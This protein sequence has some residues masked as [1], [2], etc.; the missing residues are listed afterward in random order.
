MAPTLFAIAAALHS[1]AAASAPL[2]ASATID[3]QA[4]GVRIAPEV[5]G[6]FSEQLGRGI[7]DG[8]WVGEDSSIPNINGYRKDV[9]EALKDLHVPVLRW[10]GGCYADTYRWRDGIGPRA[11]RPVTLNK[12]WGNNEEHNAFGTHEYFNFAELIG[13]KTYLGINMGTATAG[14]A[15]DWVE[16]VTSPTGSALA[17]LRRA[18]GRERPW[19]VDYAGIGNESWG[20]GGNLTAAQYAPLMRMFGTFVRQDGGPEIV[21]VG[22]SAGDYGWTEEIMKAHDQFN[23]LSLHYYTLPTGDWSHHGAATGFSK[24][25]W[26][27]TFAQT[28]QM[29]ELIARHSLIMDKAD[30]AK[31]VG[32][33]VDEWGTWYDTP[34]GAPALWQ[35][36][37]LRD[38]LV[39]ATNFNIFH[40]HADRVRIANIAQ[41]VNVLQAVILTDGA[42]MVRTP[43]YYAFWMYRPFQG[44]SALP[45]TIDSPMETA[46]AS[47]VPAIDVT[48]ARAPDG[49]LY[50]GIVN[51][52][53]DR[54]ATVDLGVAVKGARKITSQVLTGAKMDSQNPFDA[55]EQVRPAAFRGATWAADNRLHVD[56]PAKSIVVLAIK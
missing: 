7:T 39:A 20:C 17:Q 45:V 43:T 40:R 48:A 33:A 6:Q 21:S 49:A 50:V 23:E 36:N 37:T 31:K 38:A 28:R 52:D 5:Y 26:F 53:P 27:S 32:L 44:A 41:M 30:P 18:N 29:D 34:P 54:N 12:W 56:M 42:K 8:I 11:Q 9:V 51:I 22:P 55:S 19:K 24:A 15:K 35:A 10:P 1:P 14:D 3:A 4:P 13:T 25:E 2:T 16:Y 46:G 47:S